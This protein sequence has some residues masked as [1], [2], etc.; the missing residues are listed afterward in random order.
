MDLQETMKQLLNPLDAAFAQ[1]ARGLGT[2][3]DT[4]LAVSEALDIE[5][6][7][8]GL[9]ALS[10]TRAEV[11]QLRVVCTLTG[12]PTD[13]LPDEG[14]LAIRC[15]FLALKL[16]GSWRLLPMNGAHG[17]VSTPPQARPA[18]ERNPL[19]EVA[20]TLAGHLLDGGQ[21]LPAITPEQARGIYP[22]AMVD[23]RTPQM[24]LAA[25]GLVDLGQTVK[26]LSRDH[27]FLEFED[28]RVNLYGEGTN[29]IGQVT[30]GVTI[31]TEGS[32]RLDS[33]GL[34]PW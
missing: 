18:I 29:I 27:G 4:G 1:W 14:L 7:A 24:N 23:A 13:P 12:T 22:D 8:Q 34:T 17:Q 11:G 20:H 31:D 19:D 32:I 30:L 16:S 28:L 25:D 21:A 5:A 26:G 3:P 2:S 10:I 15:T 6:L 9:G 33:A